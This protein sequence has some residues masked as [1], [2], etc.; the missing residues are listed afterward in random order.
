[1]ATCSSRAK[2]TPNTNKANRILLQYFVS[3]FPMP[4]SRAGFKNKYP[5]IIKKTGTH[6]QSRSSPAK[7]TFH[8]RGYSLMFVMSMA[9]VMVCSITTAQVAATR[10][11]SRK[12]SR[13]F[14]LLLSLPR[15]A[16]AVHTAVW[17]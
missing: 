17:A 10:S 15:S 12:T 8:S 3:I 7:N 2:G 5:D 14:I 11:P 9:P 13:F 16:H 6:Q 4:I 1:M